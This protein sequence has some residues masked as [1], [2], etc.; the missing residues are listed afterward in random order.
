MR[1][2]PNLDRD[3]ILGKLQTKQLGRSLQI[4]D[5]CTS[6]NDVAAQRANA[7]AAHGHTVL[8]EEQTSGRGRQ[9]RTWLSP[10][11]GIWLTT[12]LRFPLTLDPLSALPIIGA[13]A[14]AKTI[15]S[16]PKVGARVRW[17]NDILV[18]DRKLAG[19]IA[20]TKFKGDQLEYALLGVGINANFHA[21]RLGELGP[22]STSLQDLLGSPV[23]R[24]AM[25]AL[26]LMEIEN[27]YEL[28][29]SNLNGA[30]S[31]LNEL[32]C[33]RGRQ[34]TIKVEGEE[35]SGVVADYESF[36][37]VR[38]KTANGSNRLIETS[39]AISVE[40]PHF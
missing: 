27:V 25:I 21:V 26:L 8:A 10:R 29:S 31:L 17:P 36:A 39:S 34:V 3:S 7:G 35:V 12:V 32:D 18:G 33:S 19:V 40:Y 13:L 14:A 30:M 9:G 23:E 37:I 22:K 24:E 38:I 15:N 2:I 28:A 11:G 4:L 5:K 1:F 6:T 16:N 20:G